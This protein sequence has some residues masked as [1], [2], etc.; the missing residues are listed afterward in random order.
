MATISA[1]ADVI[2]RHRHIRVVYLVAGFLSQDAYN[3][4][5]DELYE[6]NPQP[7]GRRIYGHVIAAPAT[8]GVPALLNRLGVEG[9][10]Q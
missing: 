2:L 5:C 1:P 8:Q 6:I 3:G 10:V 4:R 9:E 7:A